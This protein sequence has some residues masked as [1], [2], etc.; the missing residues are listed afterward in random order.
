MEKLVALLGMLLSLSANAQW[1]QS[2]WMKDCEEGLLLGITGGYAER[3]GDLNIGLIHTNIN[4]SSPIPTIEYTNTGLIVGA[5]AGYQAL[6]NSWLI[7]VELDVQAQDM[8]SYRGFAFT[9]QQDFG[10]S[11]QTRYKSS[12][13]LGLSGRLGYGLSPFFMPYLRLGAEV[14]RDQLQT[15]IIGNPVIYPHRL[16]LQDK[17]WIFRFLLGVGFEFPIPCTSMTTRLE[18]NFHSKGKTI[19]T[20]GV[21]VDGIINPLFTAQMQPTMQ[22][23]IVSLIWNFF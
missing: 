12:T 15:T 2:H 10:W 19:E 11:G 3:H 7:G 5:L 6:C 17:A 23:V 22:T 16:F 14:S 8:G 4:A 20:N 21:I 13:S 1:P 9:D 18:Y